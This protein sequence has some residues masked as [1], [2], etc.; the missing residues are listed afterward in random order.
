MAWQDVGET[1]MCEK[2][3]VHVNRRGYKIHRAGSKE[4]EEATTNYDITKDAVDEFIDGCRTG[5]MEN[6]GIWGAESTMMAVMAREAIVSGKE[7][8]WDRITRG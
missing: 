6:A 1:F 5:K 2:G 7:V 8:T 3:T 4:V